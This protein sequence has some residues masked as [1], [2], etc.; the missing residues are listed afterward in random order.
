MPG[1]RQLEYLEVQY[2]N[3][4][5]CAN[6]SDQSSHATEHRKFDSKSPS[7]E[8]LGA[9]QCPNQRMFGFTCIAARLDARQE[10]E[11]TG[12]KYQGENQFHCLRDPIHNTLDLLDDGVDFEHGDGRKS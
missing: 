5:F 9:A 3:G 11:T 1:D 8:T 6:D 2:G 12:R 10:H 4:D 7:N